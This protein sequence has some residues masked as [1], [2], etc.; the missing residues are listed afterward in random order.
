MPAELFNPADS[1]WKVVAPIPEA[2]TYHSWAILLPDATV[3]NGGGGLCGVG[4]LQNHFTAQV[5]SPP[6]LYN[7]DNTL[8][9][10]PVISSASPLSLQPGGT[11]TVTLAGTGNVTFSM[12]RYGSATH[13][14]NTDQRRVPLTSVAGST[15][16]TYTMILPSD[17][18][19]ML[20]GIWML[21]VITSAGV[22]SVATQ[23]TVLLP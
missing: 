15:S 18:G 2:R 20:P 7:A 8:A 11:L 17:A 22:P 4:C 13:T 10:R 5:W 1:T 9:T 6:Y 14:V 19:V 21:F 16:G 23:I 12:I 3:L